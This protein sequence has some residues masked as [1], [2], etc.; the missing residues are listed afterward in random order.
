MD[1]VKRRYLKQISTI[2][3]AL[4]RYLKEIGLSDYS[5]SKQ[6]ILHVFKTHPIID[7]KPFFSSG[8]KNEQLSLIANKL[9]GVE[10]PVVYSKKKKAVRLVASKD[11]F[12]QSYQWR[13]L[14]YEAILKYGRKCMLCGA[15]PESGVQ[16]HVDHIKP[17]K[18]YPELALDINNL[19]ILCGVC[20][21]GKGNWDESDW[22]KE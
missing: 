17:R 21:H 6:T 16:I 1:L 3:M 11:D 14:R 5:M 13:K 10:I 20:N 15:T 4:N 22:R 2:Q 9:W 12:L 8:N 19:Q 18:K 7:E